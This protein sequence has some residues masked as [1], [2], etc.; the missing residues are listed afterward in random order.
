MRLVKELGDF[1][2]FLKDFANIHFSI[3]LCWT[4]SLKNR[5]KILEKKIGGEK[6]FTLFYLYMTKIYAGICIVIM[7]FFFGAIFVI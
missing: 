5:L 4:W 2:K 6:G 7:I 3:L 1:C